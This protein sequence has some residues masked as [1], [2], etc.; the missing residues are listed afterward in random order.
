MFWYEMESKFS[1]NWEHYSPNLS[2]N[3]IFKEV[4]RSDS[5]PSPYWWYFLQRVLVPEILLFLYCLETIV[6]IK[7][8]F[9][10]QPKI[11]HLF[12][13][14]VRNLSI[15][16]PSLPISNCETNVPSLNF[17]LHH[18]E[19]INSSNVYASSD[20]INTSKNIFWK[21]RN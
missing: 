3:T 10:F 19:G 20:N 17:T 11:Y 8:C 7:H 13:V 14:S 18:H 6:I 16:F 4:W 5:L 21:P 1:K 2:E 9:V 15:D 12:A